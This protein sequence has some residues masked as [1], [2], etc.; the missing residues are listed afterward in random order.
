MRFDRFHVFPSPRKR[1][2]PALRKIRA[3]PGTVAGSTSLGPGT[4]PSHSSCQA[5]P[6]RSPP[7][8]HTDGVVLAEPFYNNKKRGWGQWNSASPDLILPPGLNHLNAI[9]R[10][11][12]APPSSTKSAWRLALSLFPGLCAIC[13]RTSGTP[14]RFTPSV[15]F[16]PLAVSAPGDHFIL[17]VL[18]VTRLQVV[19]GNRCHD[20]GVI[21]VFEP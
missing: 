1:F 11:F 15:N 9:E 3:N 6:L 13:D 21:L 4:S 12:Q 2:A 7:L 10:S 17:Q 19:C 5:F 18:N 20:I 14:V 8:R 16:A